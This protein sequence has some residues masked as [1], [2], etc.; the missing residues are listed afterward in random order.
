MSSQPI[1][2]I[3]DTDF[4]TDCDDVGALA[5][6]HA[7]VDRGEASILGIVCS[8]PDLRIPAVVATINRA[9]GRGDIPI[10]LLPHGD[11][12][13]DPRFAAYHHHR[14]HAEE[15]GWVPFHD[16]VLATKSA[17][18]IVDARPTDAVGLYRQLLSSAEDASVVI[19]AIGLAS[20]L[21]AL[22]ASEPDAIDP[23]PGRNLV[24]AKVARLVCMA[25]AEVP[26][27]RDPFNWQM[28]LE[29]AATVLDGWPTPVAISSFGR[30]VLTGAGFA[31][32]GREDHPV[33]RAYTTY[34]NGPGRRR[35]SW[36]QIA[37][38]CAVR[39]DASGFV[40]G[41]RQRV[42][43]DRTTGEHAWIAGDDVGARDHRAFLQVASDDHVTSVIDTLMT[44]SI[45]ARDD[46][47]RRRGGC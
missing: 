30:S 27:G 17:V 23:L 33:V 21:A 19:I 6:L 15:A 38:L 4:D 13:T 14:S 1:A 26:R 46:V 42:L 39:G 10:G 43:L 22:L 24:A 25:E 11:W 34:L 5:T 36:D 8:I 47:E 37:V 28:D 9:Y 29:A 31:A 44:S 7:L 12:E 16:A 2:V 40:E 41:E 3:L 35:P 45:G 20:A 32:L 18:A